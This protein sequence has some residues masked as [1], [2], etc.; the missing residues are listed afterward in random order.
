MPTNVLAAD[1]ISL[2]TIFESPKSS[3]LTTGAPSAPTTLSKMR[4]CPPEREKRES[5]DRR[6]TQ[7]S[8]LNVRPRPCL[9]PAARLRES[10]HAAIVCELARDLSSE[11]TFS[12]LMSLW[13]IDM[14]WRYAIALASWIKIGRA[15]GSAYLPRATRRI[16]HSPISS[17][18]TPSTFG[19]ISHMNAA[20]PFL[21]RP[22]GMRTLKSCGA[23]LHV[24]SLE[25][26]SNVAR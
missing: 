14:L 21:G 24:R 11:R 12:G 13:T 25:F 19:S 10:G 5:S 26:E 3:S 7:N 9:Q 4:T 23:T 2:P 8:N 17:R 18:T 6:T 15:S 20:H 1:P 16:P 22:N